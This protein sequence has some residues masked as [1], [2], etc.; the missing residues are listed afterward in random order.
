MS[1]SSI[2]ALEALVEKSLG[3]SDTDAV[4][5]D[6]NMAGTMLQ[7]VLGVLVAKLPA[8][9]DVTAIDAAVSKI[10]SGVTDLEAALE[11]KATSDQADIASPAV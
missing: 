7:M 2:P 3:K 8:S 1:L 6:I 4:S 11:G 9:V 10:L 5:S